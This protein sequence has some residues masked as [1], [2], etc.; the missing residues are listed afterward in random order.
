MA[1][2]FISA[3]FYLSPALDQWWRWEDNAQVLAWDDGRT[4]AF[5][6]EVAA[7][8]K[9]LAPG[10]LPP[11][12]AVTLLLAACHDDWLTSDARRRTIRRCDGAAQPF[13]TTTAAEAAG[14]WI[15]AEMNALV[16][17]LDAISRLPE[18]LRGSAALKA[19][20]AEVVFETAKNRGSTE[21]G[22]RIASAL[23][24]GL[25]EGSLRPRLASESALGA[26][27]M[28][29]AGMADGLA[30][31]TS[32]SLA[33]RV[34]TGL[35][36]PVIPEQQ[37]LSP[38]E[39]VR[40]LLADL[41][42]D[43]ELGGLA[44]LAQDLM[45]A[46][47][48]PRSL[49]M[50][51]ELPLGGVSDLTNRGTLDR[52]LVSELAQDDMTL[53]VRVAVNEALYLRRE[54]PPREPPHHR[55]ILL[56]AGI[57]MWGIPRVFGT[58][59]ALALAAM[60]D[61]AA[62]LNVYRASGPE[63]VP[64][65][66]T[67]RDGLAGHLAA[68]EP[69]AHPGAA[70]QAFLESA[71]GL[72]DDGNS[73]DAFVITHADASRDPELLALVSA[74]GLPSMYI[75]AV[76]RDGSFRLSARTRGG[77][78]PVREAK[79][80]MEGL[81]SARPKQPY[82]PAPLIDESKR[83]DE[84]P[85]IF[86]VEP[87]PFLLPHVADPM[88]SMTSRRFGLVT[89]TDDGRL[90]HWNGDRRGARQLMQDLPRGQLRMLK[91][92]DDLQ[93]VYALI[94]KGREETARLVVADFKGKSRVI[95]IA[96]RQPAPSA[97]FQR[98]AF[99]FLVAA[100]RVDAFAIASGALI[101]SVELPSG[102]RHHRGRFFQTGTTFAVVAYDGTRTLQLETLPTPVAPHALFDRE[103]HEGFWFVTQGQVGDQS[104]RTVYPLPT[105]LA[106]RQLRD[107]AP[108]GHA[109]LFESAAATYGKAYEV[110]LEALGRVSESRLRYWPARRLGRELNLSVAS[111]VQLRKK[112]TSIGFQED[113]VL[114]LSH[115][116]RNASRGLVWEK[117]RLMLGAC[118]GEAQLMAARDF[119]PCP[120]ASSRM[121]LRVAGWPDGSRAWLDGRG[122]LHLRSGDSL[123]P[124]LSIA[125]RD[126]HHPIADCAAAWSSQGHMIGPEYFI[127]DTPQSDGR[128]FRGILRRFTERLRR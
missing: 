51:E 93:Q 111:P 30:R 65:D 127:G 120:T 36:Q 3:A 109:L 34:K 35:D 62:I 11:F 70:L 113:N 66:L 108:D 49:R 1:D 21:E 89:V 42:S 78:K 41:R 48:V 96:L 22:Q 38:P 128:L 56:D 77:D 17:G 76:D 101:A 12:A 116:G 24:S 117:D 91:I 25:S 33:Y 122:L 9:R 10:G 47:T 73:L 103:G 29:V 32:E 90:L 88:R 54:S 87:F 124:E 57:R 94:V 110:D 43:D 59:V 28:Q 72:R 99:L 13:K 125:L 82:A 37:E 118:P 60:A 104:L 18:P 4:I 126:D 114:V 7:V 26:F 6:P 58:A 102:V 31:V 53:A 81:L 98:G 46:V 68:L 106:P 69:A 8:I 75:G 23:A 85:A 44:K 115:K 14:H 27:A 105:H 112:F 119:E 86:R 15:A 83:R 92:H 107:I 121:K 84:L 79:L 19:H 123:I 45:A 74:L 100:R 16:A 40:R 55:A 5:M 61:P 39:K 50:R 67:T 71:C 64:V 95:P 97:A 80:S 63:V 2:A 20:L 52:L